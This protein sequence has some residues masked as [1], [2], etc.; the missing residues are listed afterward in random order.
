MSM[1]AMNDTGLAPGSVFGRYRIDRFLGRGGMGA[2]YAAEQI[3]DGRTVAL[4]VLAATLDSPA[5]RERFLREGRTAASINHP[6]T[7]YVYRTEEID[8]SPTIAMELV[9]GGT[10]EDKVDREG[11]LPIP[12]AIHDILAIVDGLDAA[13][14]KG[15]LHRDVKPANC[16]VSRSGEV[17]VGDFGLSRPVD[18]ADEVRLTQTGLFLGTPV[19]SSPEQLTGEPLDQRADIYAVGA[20]LYYLLSGNLPYE[21]DNAVRLVAAVLQGA[22]IPLESRRAD[23]P[24][25]LSALVMKC[26]ARNRDDRFADYDALRGALE[27]FQPTITTPAPL[28]RR[29][30][31]AVVDTFV[32]SMLT[33]PIA[34]ML[35]ME[36]SDLNS[37]TLIRLLESELIALPFW[38]AWFGALEGLLG[39][40]PG[41][42]VAGLR[43]Q[44]EDGATI[45]LVR[46]LTRAAIFWVPNVL[47]DL[48][49]ALVPKGMG[50]STLQGLAT[51]ACYALLFSRARRQNGYLA[52]HDRLTNS[53]VV[54]RGRTAAFHRGAIKEESA[55]PPA[56][57]AE[58]IGPYAALDERGPAEHV[59]SAYDQELRRRVWIQRRGADDSPTPRA[60]R[61]AVRAT[62]LRWLGGQRTPSDGWDAYAA[63]GGRPLHERLDM[64]ADWIAAHH[65]FECLVAELDARAGAGWSAD[66][67]SVNQVWI[68]DDEDAVIL[69]FAVTTVSEVGMG[70]R[71]VQRVAEEVLSADER[72]LGREAWPLKS[73]E[74]LAAIAAPDATV[75]SVRDVLRAASDR[76]EGFTKRRRVLLW[77]C[78]FGPPL[79]L[80]ASFGGMLFY[81][82][83]RQPEI[84]RLSPLIAYVRSRPSPRRPTGTPPIPL[85]QAQREPDITRDAV[86]VYIAGHFRERILDRA[87]AKDTG[88]NLLSKQDWAVADSIVAAL[89]T[90][91]PDH[92]A[93]ADRLVDGKWHGRPPGTIGPI[94]RTMA[95]TLIIAL[96]FPAFAGFIATLFA[97]RGVILR[98]LGLEIVTTSG[99]PASRLRLLWR[100]SVIWI[101]PVL[102]IITGVAIAAR[103][104][105][106][107]VLAF[108]ILGALTP[109]GIVVGLK[110]PARGVAEWM[111]GTI[112]VPE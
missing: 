72:T 59:V 16:F 83:S 31:A 13:H 9:D 74:V 65:W 23:L 71:L 46:G 42:L 55:P 103:T 6:N 24:P 67:L 57:T 69:P 106:P 26:L 93:A 66:Q 19:F 86:G 85:P 111:S 102:P 52:E 34:V 76:A 110:T 100:Q 8:G 95:F 112:V 29:I 1:S 25:K 68:T 40:S 27:A 64:P 2:V 90:V 14:R 104:V 108:A 48:P 82:T 47:G 45:G 33:S 15:I 32:L 79:I 80:G 50:Q 56:S 89:P 41:K 99:Q 81:S 94:E 4:K 35:G 92:L 51:L 60:E 20:T 5:D 101:G 28:G 91:S 58:R 77:A 49:G 97:R 3:D 96:V 87:H 105:S 70:D 18:R 30:A 36:V 37:V 84:N 11:P 75:S 39:W 10:L 109:L 21:S 22:A 88:V 53:R 17:K 38:L 107:M 62:C 12:V 54:R 98:L 63:I 78:T 43:V 44:A 61:E 7:V 73:R